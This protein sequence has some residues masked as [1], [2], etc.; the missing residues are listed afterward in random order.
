[1]PENCQ[2]T[3]IG[4]CLVHKTQPTVGVTALGLCAP[5]FS[6]PLPMQAASKPAPIGSIRAGFAGV[7]LWCWLR[8]QCFLT[9]TT[10]TTETPLNLL[11][12]SVSLVPV[13]TETNETLV[14]VAVRSRSG[15]H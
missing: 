2:R 14:F 12:F 3:R 1:M 4:G 5:D 11:E 7:L 9:E 10:E 6:P 13:A 15:V 8:G